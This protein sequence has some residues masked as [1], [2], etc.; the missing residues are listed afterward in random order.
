MKVPAPLTARF[1]ETA[2]EPGRYGDG[3]GGHGLA[4]NVH[5]MA[6][7]RISRSWIQRLRVSGKVTHLGLGS[8]P[9]V[10]LAMARKAAL[11]NKRAIV[12]G[13]DPRAGGIPT[14]ADALDKVI[15]ILRDG[16]RD[17]GKSERQWRASLRD[18]AEVLM[19]KAVDAIG[20]GD[21]LGVLSPIWNTRRETGRRVRQRIGA[22]M[23]WSIAEGHRESN[24]VDAIGAALPKNGVRKVHLKA[25]PHDAVSGA[26]ATIRASKAWCRDPARFRVPGT[27]SGPLGRSSWCTTG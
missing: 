12:E 17:G 23:K 3:R 7:G 15:G 13:K 27:D 19:P 25:L 1:V 11:A 22:V 16:W 10:T 4:L 6:D 21:V 24:P 5:R 18:Y 14:F 9:V 2:N 20:P 8:Y 26:L